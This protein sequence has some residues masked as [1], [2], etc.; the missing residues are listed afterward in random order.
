MAWKHPPAGSSGGFK[1]ATTSSGGAWKTPV[2]TPTGTSSHHGGGFLH[3]VGHFFTH[4]VAQTGEHL[5]QQLVGIGPGVYHTAA[6]P[7][8]DIADVFAPRKQAGLGGLVQGADFHRTAAAGRE[9]VTGTE[10]TASGLIHHPGRTIEEDPLGVL[11]LAAAALGG[12][13]TIAGRAAEAGRVAQAGGTA[14]DIVRAAARTPRVDHTLTLGG[15]EVHPL[16]LKSPGAA[17]I[18]KYVADGLRQHALDHPGGLLARVVGPE[19]E[20]FYGKVMAE[21]NQTAARLTQTPRLFARQAGRVRGAT[22]NLALQMAGF[23]T[24]QEHIA[25]LE[26]AVKQAEA[27]AKGFGKPADLRPELQLARQAVAHLD[28]QGRLATPELQAAADALRQGVQHAQRLRVSQGS[29]TDEQALARL[30]AQRGEIIHGAAGFNGAS[31]GEEL[32]A[33]RSRLGKA[34]RAERPLIQARIDELH[35]QLVELG[36]QVEGN[37]GFYVRHEWEG[38]NARGVG[39]GQP[40]SAGVLKKA[41]GSERFKPFTGTGLRL[42]TRKLREPVAERVTRNMGKPMAIEQRLVEHQR[43]WD[44]AVPDRAM[45]RGPARPIIDT[46]TVPDELKAWLGRHGEDQPEGLTRQELADA[47]ARE[48]Q[49][50]LDRLYPAAGAV[51]PG[52]VR[53]LPAAVVNRVAP[54]FQQ[55]TKALRAGLTL[56]QT[57]RI[58]RYMPSY[59][60]WWPQNLALSMLQQGPLM[61]W[62]VAAWHRFMSEATPLEKFQALHVAGAGY[63]RALAES[64]ALGRLSSVTHRLGEFWHTVNDRF[65]RSVSFFHEAAREGFRTPDQIRQL[66]SDPFSPAYQRVARRAERALIKYTSGAGPVSKALGR[67][68]PVLITSWPWLRG[69]TEYTARFPFEHPYQAAAFGQEGRQGAKTVQDWYAKYGGVPPGYLERY[70]PTGKGGVDTGWLNVAETPGALVEALSNRDQYQSSVMDVVGQSALAELAFELAFGRDQFGRH[71]T[72]AQALE[73]LASRVVP[74]SPKLGRKSKAPA[75]P[76]TWRERLR[77]Q[78]APY[79]IAPIDYPNAARIGNIAKAGR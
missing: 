8:L 28:P 22:K 33:L 5:G 70:L 46:R 13:G 74:L 11:G 64:G 10:Q 34:T 58:K 76:Q 20:A 31:P 26:N 29:L 25:Y 6:A 62:N 56:S 41:A 12:A 67:N 17:L 77:E 4:D 65:F 45:I 66:L 1:A 73:D 59:L 60:K 75:I 30:G 52:D 14:G 19:A 72:R 36:R 51:A 38:Q 2:A 39:A 71:V 40:T 3:G 44:A 27:G 23:G 53:W 57:A 15:Q 32:A 54:R 37:G 61:F 68:A 47:A 63:A 16:A 78:L 79:P 69:A 9:A 43:L 49:D 48:E 18:Q 21:E 55:A 7:I 35:S 42:G 24:P 50:L